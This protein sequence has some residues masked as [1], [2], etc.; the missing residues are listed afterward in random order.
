M[1]AKSMFVRAALATSLLAGVA[2]IGPVP[3]QAAEAASVE[4]QA[5]AILVAAAAV[6]EIIETLPVTGT[7]MPREEV[8]AGA[9][10]AGL[11]VLELTTDQ[12]DM[13]KEGQVLARLD[14]SALEV[15]LAQIEAQRGQAN[16]AIAQAEAQVADAAI[17]VRQAQEQL[18]R[19]LELFKRK[20]TAQA[21]LDNA[22]NAFDSAVARQN[23]ATQGLAAAKSQSALIDAQE[24]DVRLRIDKTEVKAPSDGLVLARNA[25]LGAI[26]SGGAG[27]LFRIARDADFEMMADVP[28]TQLPRI[29][30]TMPAEIVLPGFD[31]PVSAKVRMIEPEVDPKSRLGKVRIA[32]PSDERIRTGMFA[33]ATIETLRRTG[34]AVPDVA[35]LYGPQGAYVQ[36]VLDGVVK[37]ANVVLGARSDGFVEVVSGLE[38]GQEF[39]ARAGTFVTDGD[40]VR[41]IR[42]GEAT[43]ALKQ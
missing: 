28:E 39:V 38:A 2:T 9:D 4:A 6:R 34:V 16:A 27:P 43:G 18:D 20:I 17:A 12:G 15:S 14:R 37:S 26:V 23:T 24:R 42:E 7:V 8:A 21:S 33:R 35:I 3:A 32:L 30:P 29:A 40:R 36:V 11:M 1:M 13:V 5:P 31:R 19:A 22:Q 10:V 41:P 25:Q